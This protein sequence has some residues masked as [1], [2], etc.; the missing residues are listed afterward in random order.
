MR[1]IT[2][3][4]LALVLAGCSWETYQ[5]EDGSTA[6]R[7]KYPQGTPV[8]YEDGTY[9]HNMRNNEF[10]PEQHAIKQQSTSSEEAQ[11]THWEKPVK[12]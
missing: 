3:M 1:H 8:Y 10:R 9:S 5:R 7:Q 6:L 12:K 4:L 11:G 2:C